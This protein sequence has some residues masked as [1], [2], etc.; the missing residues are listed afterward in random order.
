[1]RKYT[2]IMII[3][4][5]VLTGICSAL[6]GYQFYMRT[7]SD[8]LEKAQNEIE[9]ADEAPLSVSAGEAAPPEPLHPAEMIAESLPTYPMDTGTLD[10][11][12]TSAEAENPP[13]E[14]VAAA[15]HR[16]VLSLFDGYVAV[17]SAS[18]EAATDVME[19]TG[20]P[21]SALSPDERRRLTTGIKIFSE[22]QLARILQDY[23]S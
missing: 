14:S 12:A 20:T 21:A 19:V 8:N 23:G 3:I 2:V 16:Y 22:D 4:A 10:H 18:G 15:G 5:C 13:R 9:A 7:Q 17:F 11:E 1:M 6:L